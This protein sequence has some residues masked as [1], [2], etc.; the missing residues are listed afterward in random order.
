MTL[1]QSNV[2]KYQVNLV[3]F[4]MMFVIVIFK[5]LATRV[6]MITGRGNKLIRSGIILTS[7]E[8]PFTS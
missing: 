3:A 6:T 7:M 2:C 1:L 5:I 4:R 8:C